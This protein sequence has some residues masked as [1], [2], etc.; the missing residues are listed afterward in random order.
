M[1]IRKKLKT[2]SRLIK[3]GD[4]SAVGG[5]ISLRRRRKREA[6]NYREWLRKHQ[7]TEADRARMRSEISDFA[8]QPLVSVLLPVYDIKEK[9]L[10]ACIESVSSQIYENW[11]LCIAD[12]FSTAAHVRR[13][14]EEYARRDTRL[15]V[16]FRDANGHISAASNSALELAGGEFVALLDHDDEL[17]E[18][19]LFE[20]VKEINRFPDAC[21]IY[22]DEDIIDAEG[23]RSSP[24]FKP[25]WSPDFFYSVNYVTHL[26]AYR[27]DILRKI[28][29]FRTGFEGSQDYDL[30]LRFIE[31]IDESQIRHIPQILYHWRAVEG[32][33]SFS[34]DAKSYAH[35]RARQALREHFERTGK[36]ARVTRGIY[37]LH[38][39]SYDLPEKQPRVSLILS[40]K[41]TSENAGKAVERFM[42]KTDYQNLEIV[43][44]GSESSPIQSL[45]GNVKAI[46]RENSSTAESL[47][48]AVLQATGDVLCF[49]NADLQP[50]SKDWL[51]E[52]AAF[53]RQKE[54]GAVGGKIL[55]RDETIS[56]GAFVLGFDGAV[57]VANRNLPRGADE[58]LY[59]TRVVG[60]FSG[61][62]VNCL[63]ARRDVFD[64]I[65]GFDALNLPDSLFDAD[66]CL[67][68]RA[69]NLRIV[70]TPYAELI[71]KTKNDL[72]VKP[73]ERESEFFRRKW[74]RETARDPFYNPNLSLRGE[75]F[76]IEI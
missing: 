17:S 72:T 6:K 8:R 52:L 24:K 45:P 18:D 42:E 33:V 35:E 69:R 4:W 64:E 19:A 41:E 60:N 73:S 32:S 71:Q 10:R 57:G 46:F 44:I 43:L 61:V 13:V 58:G 65:G 37:E 39:A 48:H 76:T 59:R 3:E 29:G 74:H 38:R 31:Q 47:N 70:F 2:V 16:V 50:L 7:L 20:I 75:T 56:G 67:R 11:E 5:K 15:K 27:T 63:A 55:A 68:L 53:A 66:F 28:G 62:S 12:D 1:E 22:S 51:R 34:A 49:V 14:L 40:A 21:F 26:A 23:N 9:F 36:K 30:A 25:D 54:I